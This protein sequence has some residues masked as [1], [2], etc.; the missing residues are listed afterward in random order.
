MSKRKVALTPREKILAEMVRQQDAQRSVHR[1]ITRGASGVA[2]PPV[3]VPRVALPTRAKVKLDQ[4]EF[5][6]TVKELLDSGQIVRRGAWLGAPR[7]EVI[8]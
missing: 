3:F 2:A 8:T 4:G 5:D 7:Y 1:G 6:R